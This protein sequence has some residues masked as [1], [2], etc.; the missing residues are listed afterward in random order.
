M[1]G[2]R[3][4]MATLARTKFTLSFS[5]HV[6]PGPQAPRECA[7]LTARWTDAVSAGAIVAGIPPHSESARDLLW[8][9]AL[10]DVGT[11]N[12]SEGLEVIAQAVRNWTPNR[13]RRNF[14]QS[15]QILDWRWRLR[16][17]AEALGER[18]EKLE[19][20]LLALREAIE[21]CQLEEPPP[22][23]FLNA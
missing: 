1:E 19:A 14:L 22:T 9:D 2:E 4:L 13:A 23:E 20:E 3:S 10:L 16:T 21:R 12:R 17:L 5:N 11:L 18:F 7:H 15:L 8:E 6:T